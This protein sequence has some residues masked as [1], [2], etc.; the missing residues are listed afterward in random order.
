MTYSFDFN[1]WHFKDWVDYSE[2]YN[3]LLLRGLEM[4]LKADLKSSKFPILVK[5]VL[6]ELG[7][8]RPLSSDLFDEYTMAWD[9]PEDICFDIHP[10]GD[11]TI[12]VSLV[13]LKKMFYITSP[14]NF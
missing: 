8:E 13:N 4:K 3:F 12:R 5:D 14:L 10:N 1:R 9:D 7:C 2:D 6:L 11:G